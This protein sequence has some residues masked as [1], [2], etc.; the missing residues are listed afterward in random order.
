MNERTKGW[1]SHRVALGVGIVA[2]GLAAILLP[3]SGSGSAAAR[4][5]GKNRP[6]VSPRFSQA[7]LATQ[8]AM[9]GERQKSPI[10]MLAAAELVRSLQPAGAGGKELHLEGE[11]VKEADK[12]Q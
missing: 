1:P 7:L 6:H 12:D 10:L 5:E 8:L 3:A 11:G 4:E 9:Q 2:L